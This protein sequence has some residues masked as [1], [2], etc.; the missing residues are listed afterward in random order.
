M[1]KIKKLTSLSYYDINRAVKNAKG[2]NR[3]N[4]YLY[5]VMKRPSFIMGINSLFDFILG[6]ERPYD[7]PIKNQLT[8]LPDDNTAIRGDWLII[9]HDMRTALEGASADDRTK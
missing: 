4:W 8:G 2:E 9:G 3:M 6:I 1:N 7:K 5:M